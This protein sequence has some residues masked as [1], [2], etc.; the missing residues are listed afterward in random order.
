MAHETS[1]NSFV[2][3]PTRWGFVV[4]IDRSGQF[5]ASNLTSSCDG[6][7]CKIVGDGAEMVTRRYPTTPE[8]V[9]ESQPIVTANAILLYDGRVDNR[10]EVSR[11]LGQPTLQHLPDGTVLAAAYEAWGAELS[12]KVIGEYAYAVLDKRTRQIVAGQDSLGVRRLFYCDVG[13]RLIASS[14]L[15][16]LFE[17]FPNLR[18]KYDQDTLREYF[19]GT[20]TPWSG[21][22][23]WSGIGELGRGNALVQ[24]GPQFAQTKVWRP[25]VERQPRFKSS[26]DVDQQFRELLF[27]GVRA[28]LRA[29]GPVLCDIS[30]GFDSSTI[31]SV[32][33]RLIDAGESQGPLFGWSHVSSRSNE[34]SLQELVQRKYKI[35]SQTLDLADHLPFQI[36]ADTEMPTGGFIQMGALDR[37]VRNF[38]AERGIRSHITGAAGDAL[39]QKGASLPV[40]LGDWFREG[41]L[42]KWSSHFVSYL[43]GGSFSAWQLLRDCTAGT[44][45]LHAGMRA[46]SPVWLTSKFRHEIKEAQHDFLHSQ[47]RSFKSDARERMY[48]WTLCFI[49]Y[50]SAGLPDERLPLAYRPLVEFILGLDWEYLMSPNEERLLMRRSLREILPHEIR[51]GGSRP[52]FLA[53]LHEGLRA[54]WPRISRLATGEQLAELGVVERQ[55]FDTAMRG[56]RAG[57]EGTNSQA[58]RTALY[59]ETWLGFKAIGLKAG[60]APKSSQ[61]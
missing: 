58:M 38:A 36:L 37:A 34:Q 40:Y 6:D 41:R 42:R 35:N 11:A 26:D 16:L 33:A 45:D 44:L 18:P 25:C 30:G 10:A 21:R 12:S 59:L 14:H 56:M 50:S 23:I 43:N 19:A 55:S 47:V 31:A 32:S 2:D 28:S 57:Y 9:N 51:N 17:Q 53:L 8:S 27:D 48:R 61:L 46:P 1:L 52:A 60:R 5:D 29:A 7:L 13:S 3:F 15:G 20:M 39:F 24:R 49:P 4:S 22:T 54:A